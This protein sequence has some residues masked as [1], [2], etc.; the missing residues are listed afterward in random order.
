MKPGM[1]GLEFDMKLFNLIIVFRLRF[2]PFH[3]LIYQ[4]PVLCLDNHLDKHNE[5]FGHMH[6]RFKQH[7]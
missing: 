5:E 6:Y 3:A 2:H 4:R 7:S 1:C